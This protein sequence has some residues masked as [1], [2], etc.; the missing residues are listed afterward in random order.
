MDTKTFFNSE[1]ETET[2]SKN[3]RIRKSDRVR[4]VFMF[5][6]P[7]MFFFGLRF[8]HY[9]FGREVQDTLKME[10][11]QS[12]MCAYAGCFGILRLQRKLRKQSKGK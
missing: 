11:I 10:I 9:I 3:E 1:M 12:V 7:V 4:Y 8:L 5:F 2:I 6:S